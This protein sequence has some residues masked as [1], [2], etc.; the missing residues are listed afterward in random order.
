[1]IA[2]LP[3]V[4]STLSLPYLGYDPSTFELSGATPR[5]LHRQHSSDLATAFAQRVAQEK[6]RKEL[7]VYYYRI[8]HIMAF[9]LPLAARP[10]EMP[11][12]IPEM[13]AYPWLTWLSW[14]LEERWRLL[15]AAWQRGDEAAGELLQIELAALAGWSSFV[16]W[17]GAAGLALGHIAGVL[18][19]ALQQGERLRPEYRMQIRQAA[20]QLLEQDTLPWY[21]RH[22]GAVQE[23]LGA[24]NLH[25]IPLIALVRSAQLARSLEHP[26]TAQLD[27]TAKMALDAW[28]RL[29]LHPTAPHT[30]GTAYDGYL[31]DSL[32]E[33][34][35][36]L[37]EKSELLAAS[38]PAL[39]SLVDH[40]LAMALPGRVDLQAPIGDVE[41][42][43][44]FWMS[45]LARLSLWYEECDQNG[46]WWLL[47]H[48]PPD[49]MPAA[50]LVLL[51][52]NEE[53]MAVDSAAPV[54]S[55]P[56]V[57]SNAV[58]LR[59]GWAED[60]VLVAVGAGGSKMSHL[61]KDGGQVVIGWQNRFWLTDPGYQQYRQGEERDFTMGSDA[62]NVPVIN[63]I[64]QTQRAAQVLEVSATEGQQYT[65]LDLT[66]CYEGLPESAR[67]VRH[68]WLHLLPLVTSP[69]VIVAD[70]YTGLAEGTPIS[71]A[72]NFGTHFAW[73]FQDGWARLSDGERTLWVSCL[74]TALLPHQL[75]RHAGSRGPLTLSHQ[76]ILSQPAQQASQQ[77][78]QTVWWLFHLEPSITWTPP[79]VDLSQIRMQTSAPSVA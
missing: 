38:K 73:A 78:A 39:L 11:L 41:P 7:A 47:Q 23:P 55:A 43:M 30:E 13:K 53:K 74:G 10:T 32:T 19:L 17:N 37:P 15:L 50:T 16:E 42:E 65:R 6:A 71:N 3:T 22:W 59:S 25:N 68:V 72:W 52:A 63:G 56:Q 14:A 66:A 33:W 64:V 48:L 69:Q 34:L 62:H 8:N 75:V 31:M 20:L 57:V 18:A 44:P 45:V 49:R 35:D 28:C 46:G 21:A 12:G 40:W 4:A 1:M 5:G 60:N 9:P 54:A 29:R 26:A 2:P 67:V 36:G 27:A 76:H 79:T 61:H 77:S 70:E 51:L 24:T 58:V